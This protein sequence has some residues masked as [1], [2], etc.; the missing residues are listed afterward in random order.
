VRMPTR[1]A[2]RHRRPS[3]HGPSWVPGRAGAALANAMAITD[4]EKA[5]HRGMASCWARIHDR[6]GD[7]P[8]SCRSVR[9]SDSD[10]VLM[11]ESAEDL[12]PVDPVIGE[13]DRLRRPGVS[14]SRCELAEGAV[15]PGGVVVQQVLGQHLSQVVLIDDQHPAAIT[16]PF[17]SAESVRLISVLAALA[18]ACRWSN[19]ASQPLQLAG[20]SL[21]G[22]CSAISAVSFSASADLSG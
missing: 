6:G 8:S 13:V 7:L 1:G 16:S 2:G 9:L 14:L 3:D 20:N 17:Q 12:L 10:L 4:C 18:P 5:D 11:C 19:S 15:R 22:R 21:R